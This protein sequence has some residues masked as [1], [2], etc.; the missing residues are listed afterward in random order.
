MP[1]TAGLV[2][3]RRVRGTATATAAQR[4][5]D[6]GGI[7]VG[8]TN[9][10]ELAMW[11]ETENR[12]YGRT[13]NPYD[14]RRIAGGSSGGCAAAIACGGSPISLGTDTGG[15]IRVPAFCCG[16]LGH[17]PSVGLVPQTFD[18]PVVHGEAKRML[19][20]GPLAR[21]AEDL[22]PRLRILSGPDGIDPIVEELEL[23]DP[24]AVSL[25]GCAC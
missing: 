9:T 17:K 8:L 19:T 4:L 13:R 25:E 14:L 5:L 16:V 6:A 24:A 12:L 2:E 22:M 11:F 15:S 23:G 7:L 18:Y 3:R 20:V 21:R 10:S 1:H